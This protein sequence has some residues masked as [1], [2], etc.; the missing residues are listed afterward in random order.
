MNV[1]MSSSGVKNCSGWKTREKK[2]LRTSTE[3][4]NL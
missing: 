3:E 4:K 1:F 2:S